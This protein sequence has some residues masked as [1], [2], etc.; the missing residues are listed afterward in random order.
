MTTPEIKLKYQYGISRD[1]LFEAAKLFDQAFAQKFKNA[2]PD[3]E[4]R[5]MFWSLVLNQNQ[6][7][8][9]FKENEIVGISLLTF[10]DNPGFLPESRKIL[11][12]F[13]GGLKGARA[14]FYFILYSKLD[15]K[16]SKDFVYLEAISVSEKFR[17][18]GIGSLIIMELKRLLTAD[19]KMQL[20]LKV[21][22]EN[23]AARKLYE[24]LGFKLISTKYTP[25]LKWFTGVSGAITMAMEL[26]KDQ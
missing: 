23:T 4:T 14:A 26:S 16:I 9:A 22:L 12:K 5:I 6:I 19:N 11:F 3:N 21:T 24:K 17:G 10:S 7:L 15:T 8:A 1:N 2:I 25:I 20:Q 13:L 18:Q